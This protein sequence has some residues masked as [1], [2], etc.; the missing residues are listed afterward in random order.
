MMRW[1]IRKF[2]TVY[3]KQEFSYYK[4]I[5]YLPRLETQVLIKKNH[6]ETTNGALKDRRDKTLQSELIL[7][8][9]DLLVD[10]RR[11]NEPDTSPPSVFIP[12][13][14]RGGGERDR[15]RDDSITHNPLPLPGDALHTERW[16]GE[17]ERGVRFWRVFVCWKGNM[18]LDYSFSITVC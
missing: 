5:L 17:V 11:N 18:K 10:T 2:P 8:G 16:R 7:S 15:E 4:H 14:T 9:Q 1:K 13:H 6:C 3:L 12:R